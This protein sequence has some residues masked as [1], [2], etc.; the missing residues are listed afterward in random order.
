LVRREASRFGEQVVEC[1]AFGEAPL[2]LLG[3]RAKL[4]VRERLKFGLELVDLA[5]DRLELLHDAVVAVAEYLLDKVEHLLSSN[6]APLVR[7]CAR[8]VVRSVEL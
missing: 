6:N 8:S 2:E 7:L 3:L 4:L 1:L 5:D